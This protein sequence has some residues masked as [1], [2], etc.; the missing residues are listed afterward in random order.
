MMQRMR[1]RYDLVVLASAVSGG[2]LAV[3]A[4]FRHDSTAMMLGVIAFG[5]FVAA[6]YHP[7]PGRSASRARSVAF[8]DTTCAPPPTAAPSVALLSANR[9]AR[10]TFRGG[11]PAFHILGSSSRSS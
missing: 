8:A 6:G 11:N 10:K 3:T 7:N 9:V 1:R 5:W 2:A 4:A